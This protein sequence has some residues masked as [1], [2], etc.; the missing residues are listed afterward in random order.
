MDSDE[1]VHIQV[2]SDR[3]VASGISDA[4]LIRTENQDSISLD[5]EGNFVILA[6]GMG[7]HERGA[8]ASQTIIELLPEYLN[9]EKIS[10]ELND[11]TNVEGVPSEVICLFSL[12]DK[13]VSKANKLL[14]D[15]N[16][17]EGLERYM[18]STLVG[19]IPL[20]AQY[21]VWFHVGDSRLYR[22]RDN[23]LTQLT[24]DHSAY[25]EWK[26]KGSIGQE[27]AKNIVTRAVGP[28]EGVIPDI[29]WEEC[30]KDDLYIL[31]SDGLN[32]MVTD[33]KIAS[34]ITAGSDVDDITVS[35]LN[36]ALDAGGKDNTSVIVCKI[37]E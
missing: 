16:E 13:G 32:D 30:Q 6:D 3:L 1:R 19:L 31:C 15:K 34:I 17:E 24:A 28:K 12:I 33:D 2:N 5:K 10:K 37:G 22:Y 29:N 35:L 23:T 27:P 14:Y 9:P 18:G 20:K 25:T 8:E 7:G 26:R 11:I 4:G 21:V 36:N